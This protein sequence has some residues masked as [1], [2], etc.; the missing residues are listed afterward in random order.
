MKRILS[1]A[2]AL[3][4]FTAVNA[5]DYELRVLTFEDSDYATNNGVSGY[6]S[7]LIDEPQYGGE[8]LYGEGG[9]DMGST[10]QVLGYRWF[11]NN[12]T[13]LQSAFPENF[14][15]QQ[16]YWGGGH[17]ISNYWDSEIANGDYEHQLSVYAR[18]ESGDGRGGHGH[19]G[20]D[21]FCVHY[22]YKD[23]YSES[24]GMENLPYFEFADGAYRTIDHMYVNLNTYL[25]NCIANGND[26]TSSLG[27]G[28]YVRVVATGYRS[29]G[30][31]TALFDL[32]SEDGTVIGDW[33]KWDLSGLGDVTKVDFNIVGSS[34]NGY[35]FSQP[36]YFCYDDVAVRFPASGNGVATQQKVEALSEEE[37]GEDVIYKMVVNPDYDEP[38]DESIIRLSGD[39]PEGVFGL[40]ETNKIWETYL[41]PDAYIT[42]TLKGMPDNAVITKIESNVGVPSTG[43]AGVITC[44]NDGVDFANLAFCGR[45]IPEDHGIVVHE[46]G[47][48]GDSFATL[49]HEIF[50][51]EHARCK[52]DF[53]IYSEN[54][55]LS[56]L[57]KQYTTYVHITEHTIYYKLDNSVGVNGVEAEQYVDDSYYTLQGV[58]VDN[59]TKGI[60]IHKGKKVILK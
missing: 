44:S 54:V 11:D 55:N 50:D 12:N 49:E 38:N 22:G 18:G 13:F 53:V 52:G 8:L 26:L 5:E 6:W 17:A 29:R 9:G 36:A 46:E 45:F 37:D 25:A 58:R 56:H 32:A 20:S 60:Y 59:P 23:D 7:G 42:V 43:G 57:G 47:N 14:G 28:E 30:T 34:D 4:A 10:G 3:L 16:M 24:I 15:G 39:V 33:T 51:P 40:F 31:K 35:G 21:N 1:F 2:A 19:N 41:E 27:E 48:F